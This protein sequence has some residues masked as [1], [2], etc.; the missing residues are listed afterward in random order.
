MIV[1]LGAAAFA[2]T[3]FVGATVHP[4]SGEPIPDGVMI[5]EF[6]VVDL[7]A[8]TNN[9]V[10][11]DYFINETGWEWGAASPGESASDIIHIYVRDLTNATTIDI[12]NTE[13]N[14]IDDLM[15]EDVWTTGNV[16]LPNN[17]MAQLVVE[18]QSNSGAETLYLDQVIFEGEPAVG[19]RFDR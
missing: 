12:L 14:D 8:Y 3:A 13:G 10:S 17:I 4:V 1:W 15:I 18:L 5:V 7:S 2:A 9:E 19:R 6:D 16:A 11:L